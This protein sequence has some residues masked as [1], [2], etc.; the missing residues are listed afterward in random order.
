MLA[1]VAVYRLE[2][3]DQNLDHVNVHARFSPVNRPHRQLLPCLLPINTFG[4]VLGQGMLGN[5]VMLTWTPLCS[6]LR[7]W[8]H[9]SHV[10]SQDVPHQSYVS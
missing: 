8:H 7:R 9:V 2:G 6:K 3:L 4:D 10:G 1:V 5:L